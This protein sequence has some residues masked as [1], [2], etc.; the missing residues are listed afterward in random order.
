[1]PTV[2]TPASDSRP[3]ETQALP[4]SRVQV[5]ASPEAFGGGQS[6]QNLAHAA[7]GLGRATV[8]FFQE[9]RKRA[10]EVAHT[11][12]DVE[13]SK[14]QTEIQ[15]NVSKMRGQDAF[16]AADYANQAW[17]QGISK[18]K[19]NLNGR[20][21]QLFFDKSAS[22]RFMELNKSV[23]MHTANE[24]EKYDDQTTEAAV[25]QYRT[26]AVVN[27]GDNQI[28]QQ[29]IERTQAVVDAW[30][31]RKGIPKDSE[32]YQQKMRAELSA[33]HKDVIQA[34]IESGLDKPAMDY[35]KEH[36]GDM[37]AGDLI[38]TQAALDG[39]EM[40]Q[41]GNA[42]WDKISDKPGMKFED[43]IVNVEAMREEMQK[44]LNSAG[45]SAKRQE[46]VMTFVKNRGREANRDLNQARYDM[47][48]QFMNALVTTRKNGGSLS[49]AMTLAPKFGRD[50]Y[51]QA[52]KEDAIQKMYAPP[53]ESDPEAHFALWTRV[54]ENSVTQRELGQA[55]HGGSINAR[56]W[57]SLS[58]NLY[59]VNL[60]GT[61]PNSKAAWD[62]VQALAI[63]NIGSSDKDAFKRFMYDMHMNS[64]GKGPEEIIKM[65][66]DKLKDDPNT[67]WW[68]E[69][70]PLHS[71]QFEGEVKSLDEQN[72]AWGNVYNSIGKKQAGL[73]GQAVMLQ[74]GKSNYN[75]EDIKSFANQFG[76][77]DNIKQG[78]TVNEAIVYMNKNQLP[79]TPANIK[80]YIQRSKTAKAGQ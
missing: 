8:D 62:R 14:L 57:L 29:N 56:D 2:P 53:T 39:V 48:R 78:T 7:E 9:E 79:A 27:A 59:K 43:G 40:I 33:T 67:G 73:I 16:G 34:R 66:N 15:V 23:Q 49:Q 30:A 24:S 13:A 46:Q 60:D 70:G 47:D 69:T 38:H 21:Q 80:W 64:Q 11:Q 28:V 76:G 41:Q 37:S 4:Q 19:E 42:I 36:Q 45:I 51:D 63:Q 72:L 5:D 32:I 6:A 18:I 17:S 10:D 31:E 25:Q 35:F 3:I 20:N 71:R 55:M 1:M 58:E 12:A 44:E 61:D 22:G 52:I 77:M 54:Q 26:S 68:G 74:T 50:P 75:M 65:A